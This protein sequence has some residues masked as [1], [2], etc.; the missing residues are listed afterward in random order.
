MVL[1]AEMA[2]VD[3]YS[4]QMPP[5]H[6][7]PSPVM[8]VWTPYCCSPSL[9]GHPTYD[10]EGVD[11]FVAVASPWRD[12]LSCLSCR[13]FIFFLPLC[14][15]SFFFPQMFFFSFFPVS[16][17][18]SSAWGLR[19]H[20]DVTQALRGYSPFLSSHLLRARSLSA[21][22]FVSI[23][24]LW[25]WTFS[26]LLTSLPASKCSFQYLLEYSTI[27]RFLPILNV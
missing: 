23:A 6:C 12:E 19:F 13:L 8:W 18:L 26:P 17:T 15:F 10:E 9:D 4:L 1:L 11:S 27:S 21:D 16:M 25:L 7:L 2:V 14:I 3:S 5:V 24:V 20:K 22:Y